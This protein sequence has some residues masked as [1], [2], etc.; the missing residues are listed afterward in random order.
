MDSRVRRD[1]HESFVSEWLALSVKPFSPFR[2]S[3]VAAG[4]DRDPEAGA[5]A[6][7][8]ALRGRCSKLGLAV[9]M[10]PA[11]VVCFSVEAANVAGEQRKLGQLHDARATAT[12]LM[13]LARQIV[14]EYPDSLHAYRV[15]SEAYNH[16]KKNAFQSH[17]EQLVMESLG[18]AIKAARRALALDPGQLETRRL[19]DR[20]TEQLAS[21]KADRTAKGSLVP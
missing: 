4:Y 16:I 6:L 10:V 1:N 17:D 5:A 19:L 21:I 13:A 3:S 11:A 14:R 20:I 18:Q 12:R 15:L 2:S 7:I 8:S 9:S